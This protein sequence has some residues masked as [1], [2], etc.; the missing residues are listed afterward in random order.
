M[1]SE[2]SVFIFA[3]FLCVCVWGGC[4]FLG[5]CCWGFVS[6]FGGLVCVCVC[7][8][9]GIVC[10]FCVLLF[11]VVGGGGGGLVVCVRACVRVCVRACVLFE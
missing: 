5:C 3:F 7:R 9:G 2:F 1:S 6:C 8:G 11:V 4:Y 10:C